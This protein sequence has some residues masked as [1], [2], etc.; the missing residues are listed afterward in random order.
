MNKYDLH[1]IFKAVGLPDVVE[2]HRFHPVRRWRFD[3]AWPDLLLAVEWEGIC[4]N[5][6]RH[7][8]LTGYTNDC[9]KYNSASLRGWRVIRVT[10]LFKSYQLIE[11]LKPFSKVFLLGKKPL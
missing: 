11:L 7:T 9:H 6:S 10:S 2:E 8:S 3:Y 4:S 5:K 1:I